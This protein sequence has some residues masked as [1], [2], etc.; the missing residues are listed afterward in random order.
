MMGMFECNDLLTGSISAL[1][2]RTIWQSNWDKFNVAAGVNDTLMK[3]IGVRGWVEVNGCQ[4]KSM[5]VNGRPQLQIA[6]TER[7][8]LYVSRSLS[9]GIVRQFGTLLCI[10]VRISDLRV[11]TGRWEV[12]SGMSQLSQHA[13]VCVYE[14]TFMTPFG[15]S[16]Y[17]WL[18]ETSA[19]LPQVDWSGPSPY[20]SA[21]LFARSDPGPE[22]T[23]TGLD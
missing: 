22:I 14:S 23:L 21:R 1:C 5:E 12:A 13:W 10:S 4:W 2:K 9:L 15:G 18:P 3:P 11:S 19:D 17:Y 8:L 6:V 20:H 7:K 16:V